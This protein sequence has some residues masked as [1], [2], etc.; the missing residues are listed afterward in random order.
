MQSIA[1]V[2]RYGA[3]PSAAIVR[4]AHSAPAVVQFT[5]EMALPRTFVGFSSTD[6]DRFRLMQAWKAHEHIDFNFADFQLNDAINSTNEQYIKGLI[7]RKIV[8]SDTYALLIGA[9]TYKKVMYVKW[10]VEV[11]VEEGCRLVGINLNNYRFKDG[12]CPYF[13]ASV[14]AMF[15]PF[16]PRIV[17]EALSWQ[18]QG[19]HPAYYFFDEVYTNLGY[20]LVGNAAVL[21]PRPN[22]FAY[23][24]RPPW[25][26]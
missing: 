8:R 3:P 9:D 16:S 13:F 21:P 26:R 1:T 4:M 24:T 6:I 17:A 10:E 2:A 23:G 15:V 22:P 19:A 5:A 14:G 7:R 12:L 20:Q 25:A 18:K 11:A